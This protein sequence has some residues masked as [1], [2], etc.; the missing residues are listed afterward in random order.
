MALEIKDKVA[1][2]GA[3]C[4]RLAENF[5][6][7]YGDLVAEAAFE[8]FEQAGVGPKDIEAAW[9]S[10]AFPDVTVYHGKAGHDL[11]EPL[12]LYNIPITRVSNFCGSA[13]D[14]IQ[15][16]AWALL[17]GRY[18]VVLALGVEKLRDRSPQNSL[19]KMMVETL[20]PFYQKG[21]TAPGTFAV[22]ANR[23][24]EKVGLK[25]EHL[26]KISAKNHRFGVHNPKA[27]YRQ[28]ISVEDILKAPMVAYP[29]T[30]MDCCPTTD[31]AA[32]LV[33]VRTE[34]AKSFNKEYTLIKGIGFTCVSGWDLPH[35]DPRND[36]LRFKSPKIAAKMAYE[37]AG[38]K[39]PLKEIDVAEV[40]DCFTINEA[41]TYEALGWCPSVEEIGK[42]IDEGIFDADGELPVNTSGGLLS[43]GHPVGATGIRMVY[44]IIRQLKGKAGGAQVKNAQIG[45]TENMGGPASIVAIG[46]Y[47]NP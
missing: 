4:T 16:A 13:G 29:L 12:S 44:D 35:F 2:V 43:C 6:Q 46:I 36:F 40:H 42:Y 27:Q 22:Y 38:I 33:M 37:Q 34:D 18:R 11:G 39:N 15:N 7:S 41:L 19:V 9:L 30:V 1:I 26:A 20:H 31:G 25:R 14:A 21:F 8:A 45:L 17:A 5:E 28:E 23:L 10:T 47:G 32:A 24:M 3:G